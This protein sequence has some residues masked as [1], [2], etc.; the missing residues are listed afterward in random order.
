MVILSKILLQ[1][2]ALY[3]LR[4]HKLKNS[5]FITIFCNLNNAFKR[6]RVLLERRKSL[7]E[8]KFSLVVN[9]LCLCFEDLLCISDAFSATIRRRLKILYLHN[10]REGISH[11]LLLRHQ[12][13]FVNFW[14]WRHVIYWRTNLKLKIE[15]RH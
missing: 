13:D 6:I 15:L 10:F 2:N 12:I 4:V 5:F 14:I 8:S 1:V 7:I 11:S 9:F 3:S